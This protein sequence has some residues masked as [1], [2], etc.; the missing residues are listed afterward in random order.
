[1]SL[2]DKSD[3]EILH[4]AMPIMDNLMEGSTERDW[5]KHTKH[6][7]EGARASLPE[8]EL[9][10]QCDDYKSSHGDFAHR[11]LIGITRHPA[12]INVLWKQRM[13][14]APGEYLAT[15]TLIEKG[16]ECQ[17]RR[18]WVDLWEPEKQNE[19]E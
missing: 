5:E 10:R 9:L 14:K 2:Q 11:E 6:F 8:K 12:Y 18:C 13:T 19:I 17:V 4:I 16:G 3:E 7:T 15:L 1:M